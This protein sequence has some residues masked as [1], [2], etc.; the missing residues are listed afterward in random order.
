MLLKP[1]LVKVPERKILRHQHPRRALSQNHPQARSYHATKERL[2]T[3]ASSN[4]IIGLE[5]GTSKICVVVGESRPDGAIKI[6]GVGQTPS[7]GVRKGEIVDFETAMKCVHEAVVDA[8]QKSDVMIRSVYVAVAGSHLQS[9]NNRGCVMLPEDRDEIDEQDVEDVKINAREVSIPAQ[10]AFLHSIIQHYH[11]DG[12]DGVLSP[13]GMLGQRL[14]ADFHIIH[15]V[16]TRIQNTIRCVKELPLDVEDVVFGG[17]ASAQ[18]VLTQHQKDLGALVIDMGG[19]TTDYILYNDGA[20]K[21]SGALGVGGDHITNDISMGLR[22][23]MARAEKLKIEEGSCI[24]GNCFPGEMILLKDDSGFAG[25]EIERET[26]NTIIH[27]R[28]RETLE[29]LKRQLDEESFIN[30]IGE[31]IFITGGCSLLRGIDNLAEEIFEIPAHLAHAQTTWGVTSAVEDPQ[32]STAIGLVRFA[33][34]M[35]TDR[36]RRGLRET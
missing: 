24:L 1:A 13:V 21:Q 18:V 26:L 17:L 2:I 20:V 22:I 6:L 23:P 32:F 29:L 28:L 4:L 31:G 27:L 8:E 25:K 12:Q 10:N 14:E 19:G 34:V 16:R 7:R 3:M 33:Q 11:V 9:F 5:I 15:G 36:P 35:Q 30:F